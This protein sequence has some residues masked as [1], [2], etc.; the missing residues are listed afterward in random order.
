MLCGAI[1][2]DKGGDEEM[3]IQ[4]DP[5]SSLRSLG[6]T[7]IAVDAATKARLF[8]LAGDI[9]LCDY[10]RSFSER[11]L[12]NRQGSFPGG[13]MLKSQGTLAYMAEQVRGMGERLSFQGER[14]QALEAITI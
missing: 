8:Q 13:G 4:R 3:R 5:G 9:P 1:A 2:Y 7:T 12:A 11:E 14:L 6:M 10:L